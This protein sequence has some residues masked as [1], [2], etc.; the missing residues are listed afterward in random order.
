MAKAGADERKQAFVSALFDQIWQ[1]P[2]E[3]ALQLATVVNV[4]M[5]DEAF[6]RLDSAT[7][8][9]LLQATKDQAPRYF[10]SPAF[11]QLFLSLIQTRAAGTPSP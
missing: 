10:P 6:V 2:I 7:Q 1:R 11:A 8:A 4:I 5:N 9:A 3:W